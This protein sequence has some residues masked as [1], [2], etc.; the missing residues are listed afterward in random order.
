M[1][2]EVLSLTI[3]IIAINHHHKYFIILLSSKILLNDLRH[4]QH[5]LIYELVQ[6]HCSWLFR[7]WHM[8]LPGLLE[9]GYV[10]SV[11]NCSA[12]DCAVLYISPETLLNFH[13]I[14]INLSSPCLPPFTFSALFQMLLLWIRRGNGPQAISIGRT[15]INLESL[16]MN[17]AMW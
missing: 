3:C 8:H 5:L 11:K 4:L 14:I 10:P 6:M 13:P 9:T 1:W 16:F 17:W 12:S 15:V 2:I 7:D